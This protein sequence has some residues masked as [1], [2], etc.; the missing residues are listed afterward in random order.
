MVEIISRSSNTILMLIE[1]SSLTK[2]Y[3]TCAR[4][5]YTRSPF[6][7]LWLSSMVSSFRLP[8]FPGLP[9][10]IQ[11]MTHYAV[12]RNNCK[13]STIYN[14]D[15]DNGAVE[16]SLVNLP[17]DQT[18]LNRVSSSHSARTLVALA[19][20][21]DFSYKHCFPRF[22]PSASFARLFTHV[23]ALI[24]LSIPSHLHPLQLE[25]LTVA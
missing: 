10:D 5:P 19:L 21:M 14:P 16:P 6:S 22:P 1:C 3:E 9:G 11:L 25:S 20:H 12:L 17:T 8:W 4:S 13:L 24:A 7:S 2:S 18:T 15:W 23:S